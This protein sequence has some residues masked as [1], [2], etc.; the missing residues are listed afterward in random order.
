MVVL[1]ENKTVITAVDEKYEWLLEWWFDNVRHNNPDLPITI[2]DWGMS[3]KMVE[4]AMAN[5]DTYI[6]LK[7]HDKHP[8]FH[9]VQL[10]IWAM[11]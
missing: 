2:A 1:L 8:W 5:A 11:H 3:A 10:V 9:T 7:R 6:P 4:W